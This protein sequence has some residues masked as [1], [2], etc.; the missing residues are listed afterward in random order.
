MFRNILPLLKGIIY[1]TRDGNS[2][3]QSIG[4]FL[5]RRQ[6]PRRSPPVT[7]EMIAEMKVMYADGM[8]QHDIAAHFHVNQGRVSEALNSRR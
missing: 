2:S 7:P 4:S 8:A 3:G 6:T 5:R 1:M